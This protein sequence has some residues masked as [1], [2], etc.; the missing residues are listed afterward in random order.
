MDNYPNIPP[1]VMDLLYPY[2]LKIANWKGWYANRQQAVSVLR[3]TF[4][5]AHLE[6]IWL[7]MD[8]F[9]MLNRTERVELTED[10]IL[11]ITG[12]SDG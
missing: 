3:T 11:Y 8:T 5:L 10:E 9:V 1:D 7:A 4:L 12:N 6:P 2:S